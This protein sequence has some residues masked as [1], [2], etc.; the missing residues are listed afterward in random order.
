MRAAS[1]RREGRSDASCSAGE[2][3]Q[4]FGDGANAIAKYGGAKPGDRT[5]LDAMLPACDAFSAAAG[6]G[7]LV[8][9]LYQSLGAVSFHCMNYGRSGVHILLL[10]SLQFVVLLRA[11]FQNC[12]NLVPCCPAEV[13]FPLT[14]VLYFI[15]LARGTYAQKS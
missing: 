13:W 10:L 2:L 14:V 4:A 7:A 15:C 12:F 5:M 1:L 6:Q 8:V 11:L 9:A 3:A